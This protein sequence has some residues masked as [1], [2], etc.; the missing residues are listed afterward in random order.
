MEQGAISVR[1]LV[2]ECETFN[3]MISLIVLQP[4]PHLDCHQPEHFHSEFAQVSVMRGYIC[5]AKIGDLYVA[6][7]LLKACLCIMC[8]SKS[9]CFSAYYKIQLPCIRSTEK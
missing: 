6:M 5:H 1:E 3:A 9:I 2:T 8:P 4:L 7:R